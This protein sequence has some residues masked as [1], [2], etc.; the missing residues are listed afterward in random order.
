MRP[1]YITSAFLDSFI[2]N[3]LAE[4]LGAGD[5]SSISTIPEDLI[6]KARLMVK[7][8][9]VLAGVDLSRE[10]W[11]KLDP[12]TTVAYTCKDGDF[13]ETPGEVCVVTG[14]VRS[15]LAGERLVLN[16]MQRMSGIA[17][18]TAK[19]VSL[20]AGSRAKILDTRKTTPNFRLLEKWAV[21]IG[22]GENHRIGLYDMLLLKDNHIDAA[23]GISRAIRRAKEYLRAHQKSL[24]LEVETRTLDEV[25]EALTEGVDVI[26]LDNMN[27]AMMTEAVKLVNGACLLEASGGISEHDVEKV[28]ATGVDLISVGALTHSYKSI[29]MSLKIV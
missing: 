6:G 7:E 4:D 20:V 11:R 22:G 26:M 29:D 1:P 19:F 23:G 28:A 21:H 15:I 8:S 17:T 2:E 12:A 24:R 16:C 14:K 25:R 13:I 9:C 5:F 3:A 27:P 18:K 10:I